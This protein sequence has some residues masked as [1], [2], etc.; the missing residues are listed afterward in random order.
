MLSVVGA[1]F[2]KWGDPGLVVV[3]ALAYNFRS[4]MV[5]STEASEMCYK[6][7]NII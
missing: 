1:F 5:G 4:T 6:N 3:G 2:S 7:E